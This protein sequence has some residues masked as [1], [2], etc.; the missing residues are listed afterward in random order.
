M[1][2]WL[3]SLIDEDQIENPLEIRRV[4]QS[5]SVPANT[6]ETAIAH[7]GNSEVLLGGG[8]PRDSSGL[9]YSR[10]APSSMASD[11]SFVCLASNVISGPKNLVATAIYLR[12]Q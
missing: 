11:E 10:S 8:G 2:L 12:V 1:N 4:V 5:L 3:I 7:C 9:I 6:S